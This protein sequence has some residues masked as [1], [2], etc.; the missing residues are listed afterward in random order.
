MIA[1]K[2]LEPQIQNNESHKIQM[3]VTNRSCYKKMKFPALK[4]GKVLRECCKWAL[5]EGKFY[6]TKIAHFFSFFPFSA[7]SNGQLVHLNK[8]RAEDNNIFFL[9]KT[10]QSLL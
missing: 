4:I 8:C 9:V 7:L 1:T 10:K 2:S 3:K 5:G 6:I